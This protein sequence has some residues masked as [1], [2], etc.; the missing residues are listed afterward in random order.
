[1]AITACDLTRELSVR[2]IDVSASGCLIETN[3]KFEV[4]TVGR[5]R[6]QFGPGEYDD[7]IEVVRCQAIHGAGSLY[8]VGLRFLW[9]TPRREGSIRQAVTVYTAEVDARNTTRVM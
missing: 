1:M 7:D 4:G 6:L 8:R 9:T 2:I 5:L 3:R